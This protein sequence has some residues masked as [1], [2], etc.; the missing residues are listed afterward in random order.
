MKLNK[1]QLI[2]FLLFLFSCEE[3]IKNPKPIVIGDTNSIITE[4]DS[5]YLKNFTN[6]ISPTRKKSSE[7]QIASMMVQVD[8]LKSTQQLEEETQQKVPINGFSINFNECSVVF[9]NLYAHALNN[10]QDE[11]KSNSV[12]Y[13]KDGGEFL[14]M[15]LQ[16]TG[17]NEIKVEER[18][19][20]QLAV[21][22]EG[23]RYILFDLGKF[24]TPWYNLAG[25]DQTF[26]S[27]GNN[28]LSFHE[29]NQ[30]KIKNALIRELTKKKK[31]KEIMSAWMK[32][33]ENTKIYADAPCKILISSAQWR[34]TGK[35]NNKRVQ[36]LIQFD[37]NN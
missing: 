19:T 14:E 26:I 22:K 8:S 11:R 4:T 21:E 33:I 34:I 36:K 31:N 23:E 25:K 35:S 29:V 13:L 2:F 18:L 5:Q 7:S 28:S 10:T 12:S 17:L 20:L 3:K 15:K 32:A 24:I 30:Q 1:I 16:V 37:Q 6:D 9:N 27:V